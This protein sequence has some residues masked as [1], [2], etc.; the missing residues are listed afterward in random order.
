MPAIQNPL[1]GGVRV[2][3]PY[4]FQNPLLEGVGVGFSKP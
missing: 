4:S 3:L 2:G 1:L